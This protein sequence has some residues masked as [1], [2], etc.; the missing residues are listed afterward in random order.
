MQK[1]VTNL[2]YIARFYKNMRAYV[3]LEKK[4]NNS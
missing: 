3:I 2:T 4:K 1:L